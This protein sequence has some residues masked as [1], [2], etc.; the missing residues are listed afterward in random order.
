M[1]QN[2]LTTVSPGQLMVKIVKSDELTQLMGGTVSEINIKGTLA[3]I[4]IWL[5]GS[6]TSEKLAHYIKSKLHKT[7]LLVGACDV[8]PTGCWL[9]QLKVLGEQIGV[10]MYSETENKNL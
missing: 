6:K 2:V 1:G 8:Y 4:L 7:P 3:V 9:D 5:Q 10:E